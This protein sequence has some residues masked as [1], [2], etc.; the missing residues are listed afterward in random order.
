MKT[1]SNRRHCLKVG[2]AGIFGGAWP[3]ILSAAEPAERPARSGPRMI[4]IWLGGAPATIDMWDPKPDAPDAIRGEFQ[5]IQT[6][7]PGV[8]VSEQ[9]PKCAQILDRSTLIRSVHHSIPEHGP[10]S[11]YMLTGRLPSP[12][13]VYPSLG[14]VTARLTD[15]ASSL[16][17]YVAFNNPAAAGAGALGSGWNAFEFSDEERE[18]PRGLSLGEGRD[19]DSFKSRAALRD[20][21]DR[22]FDDLEYDSVASGLKRVQNSAVQILQADTIRKALDL[23]LE[24]AGMRDQYGSRSPFGQNVLKARRLI[25]AGSRFV[26]VGFNGWDTHSNNFAQLRNLLL[27]QL[28]RALATLVSD[29]SERGLLEE[30]IVC[31]C[32]EFGRAPRV[33]GQRGRDHWSR[34]FSVFLAGSGF[35][36]G[37]VHGATD[38]QGGEPISGACTP[39]DLF[40][41]LL[42][43]LGVD[44]RTA[45]TTP[46]GRP[47]P[48][49]NEAALLREIR[50]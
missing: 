41:T 6:A 46:S 21:F 17:P 42:D 50:S 14:S 38:A 43:A 32:G 13:I 30:T 19:S 3:R 15:S 5:A 49:V 27:P 37:V 28:D 7:I 10:G 47:L 20:A 45:L 4:L 29:L 24:P 39:P 2:L 23:N 33:N 11:Q 12:A 9:L 44:D 36:P 16:P 25:E 48:L 35:R 26:T 8:V 22:Q 34:A 18:V 1:S 31:C 40:A